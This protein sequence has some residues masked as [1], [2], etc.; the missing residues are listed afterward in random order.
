VDRLRFCIP[1]D[2]RVI[3]P[4]PGFPG[5]STDLSLRAALN[6]PECSGGPTSLCTSPVTGFAKSGWLT[7]HHSRN[8]AESDLLALRLAG[9]HFEASPYGLLRNALD[10]YMSNG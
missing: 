9:S 3:L 1:A 4:H 6:H 10:S 8:E 2:S 7:K 5:S